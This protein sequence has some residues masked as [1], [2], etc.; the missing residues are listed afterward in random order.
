MSEVHVSDEPVIV[1]SSIVNEGSFRQ[2]VVAA[3]IPP[4][5]GT[6]DELDAFDMRIAKAVARVL[7]KGYPGYSW[8][9]TAESR[10]GVVHFCIP[11]LMGP[12]LK[13]V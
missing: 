1:S 10:Q 3:Y 8:L 5:D 13:Y 9:V 12:S 11:E 2:E 7:V 6:P 4:L